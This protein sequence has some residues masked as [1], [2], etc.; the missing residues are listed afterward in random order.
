MSKSTLRNAVQNWT[1]VVC[2]LSGTAFAQ[3]G[4][5]VARRVVS[6]TGV[7]PATCINS[8]ADIYVRTGAT[9]PGF[10]VCLTT[11]TWTGPL[12]TGSTPGAGGS[13]TQ[14]QF[15]SSA[16]LGGITGWTTSN[17]TTNITGAASAVLDLSAITLSNFKLPAIAA[18]SVYGNCTGGSAAPAACS[19]VNAMLPTTMTGITIDTATPTE[20][21]YLSGVT[22]AIQTQFTGKAAATA[23]TTVNSQTCTLSSTCTIPFQTNS[24]NNT[25]QAGINLLTSTAN[26]VGLTVTPTNSATNA[27]KFEITGASYTGNAATATDLAAGSTLAVGKGGTGTTTFTAHGVLLGQ[28]ASA[29]TAT[30]AGTQYQFLQAGATDPGWSSWKLPATGGTNAQCLTSNGTDAVWGACSTGTISGSMTT[31]TIP[32]AT[33]ASAVGDSLLT[34]ASVGQALLFSGTGGFS[35]TGAGTFLKALEGTAPTGAAGSDWL[36][37]DSSAHRWKVKNNS[38]TADTVAL[39]TDNLSV[40]AATTSAQLAGVLSDETGSGGGGLAVFNN[41]PTLIAPALGAATATSINGLT[42][43]SSTGTLTITNAKTVSFPHTITL[44]S[45][46][47]SSV[48][49]FPNA[50]TT[51]LTTNAAVT[52]A[53]GGTGADLSG[54]ASGRYPKANG[55]GA[56]ATSTGAAAGTGSCT[57]QVVTAENGD[58][59]PTCTTITSAYVSNTIAL[60]GTDINTSNQVTVTHLASALPVNQGGSGFTTATIHGVL[61]GETTAAFNVTSAGTTGIPLVGVTGADPAF[62]TAVVAGGGTGLTTA[63]IHGLL[64]GEGTSALAS[65]VAGTQYQFLISNG[66]ADPGWSSWQLPAT[67]GSNAQCL[68]SN[69]TNAVWGACSTGSV[70]GSGLVSGQVAVATSSSALTSYSTFLSDSSGNVT[71][72]SITISNANP[73]IAY[74]GQ[75]TTPW[76]IG[77]TSVGLTA[78]TSVTSYNLVVPSAASA[79]TDSTTGAFYLKFGNSQNQTGCTASPT[80]LCG[81]LQSTIGLAAA[82]GDV[83]GVLPSA[84]GGSGVASPTAHTVLLG[85]GSSAFGTVSVGTTGSIMIGNSAADPTWATTIPLGNSGNSG[86]LSINGSSSGVITIQPQAAAGTY[87]WNWPI[88]AGSAAQCLVS[89]GGGSTA[90]TWGAC[91]G[92][93]AWS[94]L[95]NPSG[96]LALTM[97]TGDN[98]QFTYTGNTSTANLFSLIDATGN[99][100]TGAIFEVHSVGSSTALPV[101]FTA[102]GTTAGVKMDTAGLLQAIGTGGI[103]AT[104]AVASIALTTP[105]IGAATGTS[106]V[107]SGIVSG[108][109]P[110]TVTTACGTGAH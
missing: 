26:T 18:N 96:A 3:F 70:T 105:N 84:N 33:G 75:G 13:N 82:S 64:V 49:T 92:A 36:Y 86:I 80:E 41:G 37:G 109:A 55:A 16:T 87:N 22:S 101:Q 69:G 62:G 52:A 6:G 38:N 1:L 103:K 65:V 51:A 39:F 66:A 31:G 10:Y 28:T 15:N 45:S 95:T 50:T 14:I 7:P 34:T 20:V 71:A 59:A 42:I 17:G 35:L 27:E 9:L 48:I 46:G 79:G 85:E 94:G 61:I 4:S 53:Q 57:N 100:G 11:N 5:T 67:G 44:T 8:P 74:L 68:T 40:F 29:I 47:D 106:L 43:T 58:A 97:A 107:A 56:F 73:G 21:G 2:L 98:T 54:A 12:G 108:D 25:S 19:L 77:T 60:T 24:G 88:T 91:G 90:M 30:A 93:V 99:T 102:Q 83:S 110:V 81:Y 32:V 23:A 89:Q 76:G 104:T 78:P 72:A 63:L